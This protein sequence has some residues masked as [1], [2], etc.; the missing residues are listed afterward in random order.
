MRRWEGLVRWDDEVSFRE[1]WLWLML[2]ILMLVVGRMGRT[3]TAHVSHEE[4]PGASTPYQDCRELPGA[5][6]WAPEDSTIVHLVCP[7]A[8]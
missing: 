5:H 2:G 6:T 7:E 3:L 1:L 4:G 8:P